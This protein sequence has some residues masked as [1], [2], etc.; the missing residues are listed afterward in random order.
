MRLLL[1]HRLLFGWLLL[2]SLL[3]HFLVAHHDGVA[4]LIFCMRG[5]G[6]VVLETAL[7]HGETVLTHGETVGAPAHVEHGPM[8]RVPHHSGHGPAAKDAAP[9]DCEHE[10][11]CQDVHLSLYHPE[12]YLGQ[13]TSLAQDSLARQFAASLLC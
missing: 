5:N 7:A 13:Q 10:G 8:A 6:E 9:S 12:A 2:V 1:P 4:E 3:A 11:G